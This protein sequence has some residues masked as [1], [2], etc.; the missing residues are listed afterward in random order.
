MTAKPARRR[1]KEETK[2]LMTANRYS[3]PWDALAILWP[4]LNARAL[5]LASWIGNLR[6]PSAEQTL[7]VE[8][9]YE[10]YDVYGKIHSSGAV[11]RGDR[12]FPQAFV[13]HIQP[14]IIELAELEAV[15]PQGQIWTIEQGPLRTYAPECDG[16]WVARKRSVSEQ[17]RQA[18]I[19]TLNNELCPH[20]VYGWAG[21]EAV[22]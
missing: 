3:V 21:V 11:G 2:H 22:A 19:Q 10:L 18:A 5:K 4:D 17:A 9:T 14:L 13:R 20:S 7:Y 16:T 12:E 1:Y 8:W 15:G 6:R